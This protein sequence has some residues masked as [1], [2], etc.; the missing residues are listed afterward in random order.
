MHELTG[1]SLDIF[2]CERGGG[3]C[4][5]GRGESCDCGSNSDHS[6]RENA[7]DTRNGSV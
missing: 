4:G 1:L 6:G 2:S 5:I 3:G 7:M